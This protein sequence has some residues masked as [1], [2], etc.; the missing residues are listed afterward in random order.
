M[1]AFEN[2]RKAEQVKF[3][4]CKNRDNA[5]KQLGIWNMIATGYNLPEFQACTRTFVNWSEEIL[6]SFE[7]RFSLR[8]M[9]LV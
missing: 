6:N 3:M 5:R 4:D 8:E 2:V 7:Y 1:W 9:L